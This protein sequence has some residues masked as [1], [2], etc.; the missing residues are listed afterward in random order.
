ML[1]SFA[2]GDRSG[3]AKGGRGAVSVTPTPVVSV[4]QR[5]RKLDSGSGT[6]ETFAC[7]NNKTCPPSKQAPTYCQRE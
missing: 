3:S 1:S 5:R 7:N 2:P 6:T 4:I